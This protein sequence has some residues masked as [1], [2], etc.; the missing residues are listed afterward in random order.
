MQYL[1]FCICCHLGRRLIFT[2]HH[3]WVQTIQLILRLTY[4]C[5]AMK[6]SQN[7]VHISVYSGGSTLGQEGERAPRFTYSPPSEIQKLA[8][9]SDVI[10]EVPKCSKIPIFRGS[11]PD[12]AGGAYKS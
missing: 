10:S 5:S 1:C 3:A 12:P 6:V 8:D 4:M 2:P 11:A 7:E 9:R